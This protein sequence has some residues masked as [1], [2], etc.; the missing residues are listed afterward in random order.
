[1]AGLTNVF[2]AVISALNPILLLV[3]GYVLNHGIDQ[4]KAEI[5]KSTREISNLKTTAET[6]SLVLQ[7]RVD[8]VKVISD[9]LDVLSGADE[10]KRKLAIEAILIALPDE[11]PRLVMVIGEFNKDGGQN[12]DAAAARE[13]LDATRAKLVTDT[14]AADR[15]PRVAAL[16]TLRRSWLDDPPLLTAL[17]SEANQVIANAKV[18]GGKTDERGNASLNNF[19]IYLDDARVPSDPKL[20]KEVQDFLVAVQD[21]GNDITKKRAIEAASRFK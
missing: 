13:A 12:R 7:Q 9:F 10:R 4:N 6:S 11:A 21:V 8:K 17:L 16:T 19:V 1:M 20:K 2:V 3:V 18:R 15:A 14:F 5:E